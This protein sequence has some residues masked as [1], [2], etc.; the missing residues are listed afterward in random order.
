LAGE[1]DK[2]ARIWLIKQCQHIGREEC[3]DTVAQ[4]LDDDDHQIRD[5]ARR[6]L[7][8]N[9][10]PAANAALLA[11]AGKATGSFRVGLINSLGYRGDSD[12]VDSL[13]SW[14]GD[15]DA[16]TVAA[17]ANALG[18][19]ANERAGKALKSALSKATD[20]VKGDIADAYL[21]CAERLLDEGRHREAGVI[22]AELSQADLP[23]AIRLA[24]VR[25]RLTAAKG[26]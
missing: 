21:R 16:L 23:A 10:S 25:G 8:D 2:P 18:K 4:S 9:P 6:A 26:N 22:Y 1:L 15:K 11:A 14:L 3:V 19:I 17:A 24:A 7:T 5:A 20:E 12:S 13:A